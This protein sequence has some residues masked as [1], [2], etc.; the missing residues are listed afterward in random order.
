MFY[1]KTENDNPI[2]SVWRQNTLAKISQEN[3]LKFLYPIP[4]GSQDQTKNGVDYFFVS[5]K[6]F[7]KLIEEKAFLNTQMY[8]K[9]YMAH[10]RTSDQ[11]L[12]N[13]DNVLF[14][15]DQGHNRLKI[16]F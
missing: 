6:Q 8:L 2:I 13:G 11:N 16:K 14:D 4:L 10:K 9:I 15:I 7:E 5:Q 1:Q 12:E 3:I